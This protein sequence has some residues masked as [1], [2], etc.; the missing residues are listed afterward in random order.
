[1][2]LLSLL[3]KGLLGATI[4]LPLTA[5]LP[6]EGAQAYKPPARKAPANTIGGGTRSADRAAKI[7]TFN[8]AFPMYGTV[9]SMDTAG[10]LKNVKAPLTLL[11]P[12]QEV[13]QTISNRPHI[14]FYLDGTGDVTFKLRR[15][16]NAEGRTEPDSTIIWQSNVQVKNPGVQMFHYPQNVAPLD[17]GE[18]YAL[19]VEMRCDVAKQDMYKVK[20]RIGIEYVPTTPAL[21]KAINAAPTPQEKAKRYGDAGLWFDS[22]AAQSEAIQKDPEDVAANNEF[23]TSLEEVGLKSL[24]DTLR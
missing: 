22:L 3:R 14:F 15:N 9:R 18:T 16:G 10:C 5:L 11:A 13:G 4:A 24:A 6:I 19:Y 7:P 12:D 20:T 23:L 21:D 1:M 8:Q 17:L 2:K